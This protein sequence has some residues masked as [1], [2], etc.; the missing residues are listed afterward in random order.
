LKELEFLFSSPIGKRKSKIFQSYF[1]KAAG[2]VSGF[3]KGLM[4]KG[5]SIKDNIKEKAAVLNPQALQGIG[6]NLMG[7]ISN[8]MPGKKEEEVP[9]PNQVVDMGGEMIMEGD[10]QQQWTE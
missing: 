9:D 2:G 5:F 7:G 10:Q 1:L 3:A 4:Q 6:S 8:L